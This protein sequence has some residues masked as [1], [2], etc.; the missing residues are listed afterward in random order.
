MSRASSN[1]QY[2][3]EKRF[4]ASISDK[5]EAFSH[6]LFVK[7]ASTLIDGRPPKKYQGVS[8]A[9]IRK[10]RRHKAEDVKKEI[11]SLL[12]S[13][14]LTPHIHNP[15][16]PLASR[17][18]RLAVHFDFYG[19]SPRNKETFELSESYLAAKQKNLNKLAQREGIAVFRLYEIEEYRLNDSPVWQELR[20]F[21]NF[22][23]MGSKIVNQLQK[24]NIPPEIVPTMNYYDFV[25]AMLMHAKET[26]QK[27]FEGSRSKNLKMF[28]AC[29][30]EEFSKIMVSLHY[31][32]KHVTQMLDQ[33]RT[34][35]C[36]NI[37]DL[38]HKHN[39]TFMNELDKPEEINKFPNML[40]TFIHPHHRSLHFQR[41]Y[42][43][44]KDVIFFG[45]YHA[46]YQI[47]RDIQRE[48]TYLKKTGQLKTDAKTR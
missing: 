28:A 27:P 19:S 3:S 12:R 44:D 20:K 48:N 35:K 4:V 43:V 24:N 9:E 47:R 2:L 25:D 6:A 31:K 21:P 29:Y 45:G 39:I 7:R 40:L 17:E 1:K 34:G 18:Q 8:K 38:H 5:M 46:A 30:G 14:G 10:L 13:V 42:E 11:D 37:F 26:K 16:I 33:M 32:Q 41:S 15:E 22:K 23:K 36:P